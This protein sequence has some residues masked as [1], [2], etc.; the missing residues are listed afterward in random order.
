MFQ[1]RRARYGHGFRRYLSWQEHE[2]SDF[3]EFFAPDSVALVNPD[4]K[5][6]S[7]CCLREEVNLLGTI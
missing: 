4:M 5:L 1:I 3:I 7:S 6:R 2:D